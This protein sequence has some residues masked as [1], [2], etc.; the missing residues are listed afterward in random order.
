[1]LYLIE[2]FAPVQADTLLLECTGVSPCDKRLKKQ[3][4]RL[5][6]CP[7]LRVYIAVGFLF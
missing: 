6:V 2:C 3:R 5:L 7:P 4:V 1:M